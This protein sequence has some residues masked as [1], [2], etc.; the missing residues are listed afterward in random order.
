VNSRSR[1]EERLLSGAD[2][3]LDDR[4]KH[5]RIRSLE[6]A[7]VRQ[8]RS[9]NSCEA[10]ITDV[11]SQGLRLEVSRPFEAGATVLVEWSAGFLPCTV[12]HCK[13]E[14]GMWVIGVQAELYPGVLS[15]LVALMQSAQR[16]NRTLLTSGA[17][18]VLSE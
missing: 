13:S 5:P 18:V 6:T 15:L 9:Q 3:A 1:F 7:E 4:R 8:V 14:N 12:R 2:D 17:R 11:S 10:V 16:R